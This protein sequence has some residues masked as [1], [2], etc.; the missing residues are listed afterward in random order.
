MPGVTALF[1][2]DGG[3]MSDNTLR[4]PEWHRLVAEFFAPRPG[5][6]SAAWSEANRVV[7]ERLVPLLISG[8]REQDY[9]TWFDLYQLQWLR[10]MVAYV[11]VIA[12][13][14]DV[15]CLGLVWQ[16]SDYITQRVH[17]AY[18]GVV[19]AIRTLHRKGFKLFTASGEHSRELNGYLKGMGIREYFDTLYGSDLVNLGKYSIEYY[20]RIF[21][22]AGVAPN[23]ALVVDDK[24]HNLAWAASLGAIT[25]LVSASPHGGA[26]AD[27]IIPSLADLPAAL[28]K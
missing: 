9:V 4:S 16:A 6:D 11:G 19:D 20:R 18:P 15:Q 7:F 2:D 14:D 25:C 8:P 21:D 1:M 24:L 23:H 28:E 5:G 22:H 12:P 27:F 13:I 10:E 26:E 17:S 3:V